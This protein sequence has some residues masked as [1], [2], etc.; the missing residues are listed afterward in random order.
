M[1]V[2]LQVPEHLHMVGPSSIVFTN[3]TISN[4]SSYGVVVDPNAG[5]QTF[6]GNT[7]NS[8]ANHVIWI[9]HSASCGN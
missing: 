3:N 1:P 6:T 7:I 2:L 9:I 4:S 5:F 8:C